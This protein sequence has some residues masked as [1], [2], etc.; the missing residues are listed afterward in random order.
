MVEFLAK[1]AEE[2]T[3]RD[4]IKFIDK[5]RIEMLNFRCIGGDGRL[6]TLNFVVT[7]KAELDRLLSMGERVD[8]SSLL[9]YVDAASSDLYVVPRYKT[10]Y[11]NPFATVPTVDILCS[12]YTSNGTP[13]PGSPDVI[14]KKAGQVLRDKTGLSLQAM[15]ELEYYVIYESNG[16]YPVAAQ[17]GYHESTPF[18]KWERLRCEAMQLIAQ[19]GGEIKYGHAEVGEIHEGSREMEQ[20]EIEFLPVPVE[21]AADQIVIARWILRMV[22][23]KYGVTVSFFPKVLAGHAGNGLHVHARLIQN[24]R[25]M[26]I[27]DGRLSDIA[28]K[29]IAGYLMLAPSLTAFGN[30]T[31]ASYL[32]IVPHQ[33]APTTLCWGNRNR[34]VLVR[35]PLGQSN[36]SN[37]VRDANPRERGEPPRFMDSQTVEFRCPDGSANVHLLLAGLTVATRYG[38]ETE[39]ALEFADGLYVE[40]DIFSPQNGAAREA[41]PRLPGSCWESA[42]NLLRDRE[43][44]ERDNVFPPAVVDYTV[45][46]LKRR[47]ESLTDQSHHEEL[48]SKELVD[49]CLH[50]Q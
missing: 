3:K 32:R 35:V 46:Q 30:T 45:R 23:Y 37:M 1:P 42:E 20:H 8:G 29:A 7:S 50:C 44:Y 33:E 34:S 17:R 18:A 47:H 5:Q 27:E 49:E 43:I 26:M 14:V 25:N 21:D 16:L 12:Y 36:A 13:L 28:R 22:G 24:E 39:D 48:Q 11:V 19:V 41:L 15:G 2:F 9:P 6:K 38:L 31:P 10:A 4:I 40:G